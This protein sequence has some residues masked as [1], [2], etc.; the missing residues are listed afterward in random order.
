MVTLVVSGCC[1]KNEGHAKRIFGERN[2]PPELFIVGSIEKVHARLMKMQE[3][4]GVN[5]IIFKDVARD[6]NERIETLELLSEY[7]NLPSTV[8]EENDTIKAA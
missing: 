2:L 8:V 1:Q 4:F 3:D 6:R 5:E 7:C